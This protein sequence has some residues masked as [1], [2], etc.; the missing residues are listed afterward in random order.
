MAARA[1]SRRSIR[2]RSGLG[3]AWLPLVVAAFLMSR[4]ALLEHD[5]D[6]AGEHA[7]L[8][9][10]LATA[11]DGQASGHTGRHDGHEPHEPAPV[12]G[13]VP[14]TPLAA[15]PAPVAPPALQASTAP[16]G[17]PGAAG[18]W[19]VIAAPVI[20]AAPFPARD[21]PPSRAFRSTL[22]QLLLSSRA[23]RI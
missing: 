12:D 21:G 3:A 5:H 4:A 2:R 18:A 7:H 22:V 15:A 10:S 13:H 9:A 23:L 6:G 17:P 14:A 1:R 19:S 16:A 11:H 20:V 8:L